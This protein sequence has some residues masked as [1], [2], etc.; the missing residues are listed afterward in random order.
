[1]RDEVERVI[2]RTNQSLE[3]S[4]DSLQKAEVAAAAAVEMSACLQKL[5]TQSYKP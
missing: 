5:L 3:Q 4:T 1:M 2:D